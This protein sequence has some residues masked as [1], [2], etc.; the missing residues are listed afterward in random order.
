MP[1]GRLTTR[2]VVEHPGAVGILALTPKGKFVMV[3]QYRYAVGRTLLEIPAGTRE[4]DETPVETAGRE[5][6]EETGYSAAH[7]AEF[8]RFFTSPGWATEEIILFLATGLDV[9]G[10]SPD[11]DEILNVVEVARD[12]I[13]VL[14]RDGRIADGKTITALALHLAGGIQDPNSL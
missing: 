12:D 5:L 1:D 8:A 6:R 14:M 10:P 7:L 9:G 4:P 2:E 11:P 3:E 13:P